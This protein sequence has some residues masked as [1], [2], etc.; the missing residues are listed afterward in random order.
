MFFYFY[1]RSEKHAKWFEVILIHFFLTST[2]S[3]TFQQ[4]SQTISQVI[5]IHFFLISTKSE[6]FQQTSQTIL[7]NNS[8]WTENHFSEKLKRFWFLFLSKSR[9]V[10]NVTLVLD[11]FFL[12]MIGA[13]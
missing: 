7:Q 2:K 1:T 10:P 9:I 4:T 11:S 5:L 3:K 6:T 13:G 8:D 12:E